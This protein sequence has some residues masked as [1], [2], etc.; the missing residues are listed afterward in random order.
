MG[1]DFV[2]TGILDGKFA[3][4]ILASP[5]LVSA[6]FYGGTNIISG[7]A[8]YVGYTGNVYLLTSGGFWNAAAGTG[9]GSSGSLIIRG[10][11]IVAVAGQ[12]NATASTL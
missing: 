5:I 7:S 6:S 11:I 4:P 8:E 9:I 2:N 12:L 3:T 1:F 10:G